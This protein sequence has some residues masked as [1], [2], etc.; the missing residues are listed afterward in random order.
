MCSARTSYERF[1]GTGIVWLSQLDLKHTEDPYR[2]AT[3][4]CQKRVEMLEATFKDGTQCTP[5]F[6]KNHIVVEISK[7]QW[8]KKKESEFEVENVGKYPLYEFQREAV[9]NIQDGV[10]RVIVGLSSEAVGCVKTF[11]DGPRWWVV[12]F[13]ECGKSLPT[14]GTPGWLQFL[15]SVTETSFPNSSSD[16][17]AHHLALR[18]LMKTFIDPEAA[19]IDPE[20]G[21]PKK[22]IL[23]AEQF[24]NVRTFCKR[25][26]P[27]R[28][29]VPLLDIGQLWPRVSPGLFTQIEKTWC[30][31]VSVHCFACAILAGK[32]N[33]ITHYLNRIR[34]QW[35]DI[36]LDWNPFV[37]TYLDPKS[38]QDHLQCRDP[39]V[40]RIDRE[41]IT[42]KFRRAEIFPNLKDSNL[43]EAVKERVCRQGLIL[44]LETLASHIGVLKSIHSLLKGFLKPMSR[45]KGDTIR[46]RVQTFFTKEF[47][48]LRKQPEVIPPPTPAGKMC[49]IC[50]ALLAACFPPRRERHV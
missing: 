33:S 36:T 37:V 12:D 41:Y 14:Y 3:N 22:G 27:A 48:R 46:R 10:A 25:E 32:A 17:D 11:R 28:H 1:L 29:L 9:L 45:K 50:R 38:I 34:A 19:V 44:S 40:S 26:L 2:S 47:H 42:E 20:A 8:E 13:L 21:S 30:D 7:H 49:L 23:S 43:R 15:T 31:E 5:W 4:D 24:R 35:R 18:R 6:P 16:T 39:S